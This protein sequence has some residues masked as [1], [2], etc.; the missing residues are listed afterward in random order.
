MAALSRPA[1]PSPPALALHP[2]LPSLPSCPRRRG[3]ETR[4]Q[5]F[6]EP[7]PR[8]CRLTRSR[9]SSS[10]GRKGPRLPGGAPGACG[11]LARPVA[12]HQTEIGEVEGALPPPPVSSLG[13]VREDG[14]HCFRRRVTAEAP[15]LPH[16]PSLSPSDN[17][18]LK[19]PAAFSC[20]QARLRCL[21]PGLEEGWSCNVLRFS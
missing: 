16:G 9:S 21:A 17:P 5:L 12:P 3:G 14:E 1:P 10:R 20:V 2:W 8:G 6:L 15:V 11:L 7:P 18:G 4:A 19:D 13:Q